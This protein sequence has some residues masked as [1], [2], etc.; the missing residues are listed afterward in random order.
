MTPS[1]LRGED[2]FRLTTGASPYTISGVVPLTCSRAVAKARAAVVSSADSVVTYWESIA[3][4]AARP[5][6]TTTAS[7][8]IA[9]P[10]TRNRLLAAMGAARLSL[11]LSCPADEPA[12]SRRCA[13]RSRVRGRCPARR[14]DRGRGPA[15]GTAGQRHFLYGVQVDQRSLV[16]E[17]R[18]Q[19]VVLRLSQISLCLED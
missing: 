15:A 4:T 1:V 9:N 17:Q 11:P 10:V 6:I 19:F 13:D 3:T 2:W 16:I 12:R 5:A 14:D 18:P 7:P 8:P